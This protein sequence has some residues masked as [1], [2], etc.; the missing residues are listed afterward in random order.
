MTLA[1]SGTEYVSADARVLAVLGVCE[2][3]CDTVMT[4]VAGALAS[5]SP[6]LQLPKVIGTE[7]EN[8][9]GHLFLIEQVDIH[10]D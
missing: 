1:E 2:R 8:V 3:E 5:D 6:V 7:Q 10:A 9:C 4:H